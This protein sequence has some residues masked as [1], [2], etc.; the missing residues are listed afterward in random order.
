MRDALSPARR[1]LPKTRSI[2]AS[3]TSATRRC[4]ISGAADRDP[5]LPDAGTDLALRPPPARCPPPGGSH[6]LTGFD[7]GQMLDPHARG[8]RRAANH[9]RVRCER[10]M[11]QLPCNPTSGRHGAVY[12]H[13]PGAVGQSGTRPDMVLTR[14]VNLDLEA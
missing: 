10:P 5:Q 4:P 13:L 12:S 9:P 1:I 8:L 6:R 14:A 2:A 7:N 11:H 3:S